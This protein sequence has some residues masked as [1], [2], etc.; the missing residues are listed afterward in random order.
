MWW[1]LEHKHHDT[2][3]IDLMNKMTK[4]LGIGRVTRMNI[5]DKVTIHIPGGT[6]QDS[7]RFQCAT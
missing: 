5:L 2:V 1:S 6:K 3:T 4:L 7:M